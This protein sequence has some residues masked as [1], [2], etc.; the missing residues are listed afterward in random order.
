[1]SESQVYVRLGYFLLFFAGKKGD[2][3]TLEWFRC[4]GEWYIN[5][6]VIGHLPVAQL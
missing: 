5:I 4:E 6:C 3:K 2:L 1:M